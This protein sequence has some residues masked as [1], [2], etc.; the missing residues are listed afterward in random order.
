MHA[1]PLALLLLLASTAHAAQHVVGGSLGWTS[2][3]GVAYP[4]MT[5]HVGDSLLFNY[6]A[7][8]DVWLMSSPEAAS[9]CD[10][11]NATLLADRYGSPFIYH[12]S[13]V[14]VGAFGFA[15]ATPGHCASGQRLVVAVDNGDA[16]AGT[17]AGAEAPRLAVPSP[18]PAPRCA[19]RWWVL[20]SC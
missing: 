19:A 12:V 16:G 10:F 2:L 4:L 5:A 3:P 8:H 14:T 11:S 15:C 6:T 13:A 17:D 9:S 18:A 20:D 1:A 7:M